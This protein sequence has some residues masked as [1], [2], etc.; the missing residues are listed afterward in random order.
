M[1]LTAA[2]LHG[3]LTRFP[4]PLRLQIEVKPPNDASGGAIFDWSAALY[5]HLAASQ[6]NCGERRPKVGTG[7][8][9][10]VGGPAAKLWG[11]EADGGGCN[12]CLR[13]CMSVSGEFF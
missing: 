11:T 5:R 6:R 7:R 10:S 9:W 12:D 1:E 4:Y 13:H 2:G 8:S 3:I